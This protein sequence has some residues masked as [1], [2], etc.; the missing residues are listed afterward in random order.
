MIAGKMRAK[1]MLMRPVT[2]E[3]ASGE[4]TTY[5]ET[6]TVWAERVKMS[7]TRRIEV[8]EQFPEYRAEFNIREA[9]EVGENWRCRQIGGHEYSI[10]AVIPNRE[11]GFNTLICER[12]NL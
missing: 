4:R 5:E 12:V 9:H 2:V 10:L 3:T 7:G 6:T 8:G 11:R 1:L